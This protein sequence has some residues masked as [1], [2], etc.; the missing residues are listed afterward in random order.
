[1]LLKYGKARRD[2][3]A[4][5]RFYTINSLCQSG[6]VDLNWNFFT[7]IEDFFLLVRRRSH[8]LRAAVIEIHSNKLIAPSRRKSCE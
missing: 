4:S 6:L 8:F 3:S 7:E 5:F 2:I 1:M